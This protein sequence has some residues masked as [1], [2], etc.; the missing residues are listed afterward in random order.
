MAPGGDDDEDPGGLA[1]GNA[2]GRSVRGELLKREERID[3]C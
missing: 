2:R 1:F 3:Y